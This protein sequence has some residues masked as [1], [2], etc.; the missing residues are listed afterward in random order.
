M[1][2]TINRAFRAPSRNGIL[3]AAER[4]GDIPRVTPLLSL[5]ELG[6]GIALKAESLQLGG[7]FKLR[8]AYNRL[9][10]VAPA[11]RA[12]GVVAFSSGNHAQGVAR[13]ARLL[14]MPAAIVMPAD[15][16][17]VKL[18]ATAALGAEIIPYDR[19][20]ESREAIAA[21][22]AEE[23]GAVLLPSFDD[24][25][26][27]EGQGT[28]GLEAERQYGAPIARVVVPCGGGGLAAGISLALPDAEIIIVEPEGWDDMGRSLK[29]G[30]IVPVEPAAPATACDAL[31]TTRVAEITFGAL[32]QAGARGLSVSEAEVRAAMRYAYSLG[33]V[34]EPGGAVALAAL[35]AGKVA[36]DGATTLV[37]ASGSNVDPAAFARVI[38]GAG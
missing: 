16:P 36:A 32:H 15:A 9:A 30:R 10:Q 18:E 12:R 21:R 11:D 17:R 8:G 20:T 6:G 19:A 5:P 35:L 14:G 27:V 25:D 26:V 1:K 22:L 37:V 2:L 7:A 38:G 28:V 33:L 13:A 34:V 24:V 29:L 23:R 31:Q 4:L 3:A